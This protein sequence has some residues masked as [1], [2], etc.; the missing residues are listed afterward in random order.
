MTA[1]AARAGVA[2][3]SLYRHFPSRGELLAAVVGDALAG[4]QA[5]LDR[6]VA[7][8]EAPA[9]ALA[10]WVRTAVDR[11]RQAPRLTHALFE[12]PSEPEVGAVRDAAWRAREASLATVL[13]D[14]A[15]RGAWPEGPTALQAAALA[16]A[17]RTAT[18]G[19]TAAARLPGEGER[20][21]ADR[22]ASFAL[23]AV[24]GTAT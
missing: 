22:L 3:G 5:L 18:G 7:G 11:A 23:A 10:A 24:G 6:A 21:E 8:A 19:P 15:R 1:V 13:A 4:E 20:T 16:G 12:E 14:G 9:G 17:V 2:T